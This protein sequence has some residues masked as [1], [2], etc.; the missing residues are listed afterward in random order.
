MQNMPLFGLAKANGHRK[1]TSNINTAS[2][3]LKAISDDITK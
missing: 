1:V 3:R 2:K